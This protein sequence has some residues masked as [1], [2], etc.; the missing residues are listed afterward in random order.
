MKS[1]I[2][3]NTWFV[4]SDL[5]LDASYH[6]SD[7]NRIKHVFSTLP[8]SFT[9]IQEQSEKIFS[10]NIFKRTYVK[11]SERGIPYITGSDMIKQDITSGKFLSKKQASG[12]KKLLLEKGWILVTCSGTLG[13]TVYTNNLFAN[14]IATHDLIRI[15]PNNKNIK[16]GFLYAY[17]SSKYGYTLLTQ[18]SY[19]GVVKHIEPHHLSNIP[20]PIFPTEQQQ[21][22]HDLITES[23]ELRVEANRLMEDAVLQF[24]NSLP[25]IQT[26]TIYFSSVKNISKNNLRFDASTNFSNIQSFYQTI[27]EKYKLITVCELSETVFT[28]GI[29]KRVRVD[30]SKAGI[31]FLSG[32]DLLNAMPSF[33]SFLSKKMKNIDD[34]ILRPGWIAI[35][36]AGTIGY[37]SLIN[38]YLDGVAA[39]NNLVRIIPKTE[40]NANPYIY[41]FLKTKQG[42]SILKSFEYGSVQ[43]HIDN[44]QVSN[45]LIPILPN[46]DQIS[47]M[48]SDYLNK[49]TEACLKENQAIQLVENEIEQ[50]QN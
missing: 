25:Q 7:T 15:V 32:S 10:G 38:G 1:I 35:Q 19:G 37:V 29:F 33:D 16:E 22:I 48:V 45:L 11:D 27:S 49:I 5:R 20:V 23:A 14:S 40:A 41:A 36:D 21:Q 6:L 9:T 8:Y 12:L 4:E 42:Q 3:K 34:Y 43:K 31:P 39:T 47:N 44:N 2:A 17:L 46:Y 50:W 24:E 28:P 18:S 30:N 26:N 13:N